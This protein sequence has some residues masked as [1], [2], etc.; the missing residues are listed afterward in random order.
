MTSHGGVLCCCRIAAIHSVLDKLLPFAHTIIRRTN[1]KCSHT[2]T[3]ISFFPDASTKY[4]HVSKVNIRCQKWYEERM[5][6]E[7]S[8]VYNEFEKMQIGIRHGE[9]ENILNL[10]AAA[11]I[12]KERILYIWVS[13]TLLKSKAKLIND[14]N[15]KLKILSIHTVIFK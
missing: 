1:H 15:S 2:A 8:I 6:M 14:V 7:S 4:E 13:Q 9:C 12:V 10:L 3:R 11:Y 5:S